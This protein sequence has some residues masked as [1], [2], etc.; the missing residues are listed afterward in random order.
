MS[1]LSEAGRFDIAKGYVGC[2]EQPGCS[3]QVLPE[4]L[5]TSRVQ[6]RLTVSSGSPSLRRFGA[7]VKKASSVRF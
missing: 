2:S 4:R 5:N 6:S 7:V 3:C 1:L